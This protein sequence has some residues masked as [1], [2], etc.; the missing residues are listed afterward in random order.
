MIST[1]VYSVM[2]STSLSKE[3]AMATAL[4]QDKNGEPET[5]SR[6]FPGWKRYD[7]AGRRGL[8]SPVGRDRCGEHPDDYG[9]GELGQPG[10]PYR[11]HDTLRGE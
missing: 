9:D 5:Y 2:N 8:S 4:M 10:P 3:T 7:P 6:F 11:E 1:M